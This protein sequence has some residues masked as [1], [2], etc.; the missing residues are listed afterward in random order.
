MKLAYAIDLTAA[1]DC[2]ISHVEGLRSVFR[3]L[4][5]HREQI[6]NRDGEFI[7]CIVAQ[8]RAN[9]LGI[10]AVKAG[11]DGGMRGE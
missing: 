2:K 5:S 8:I 10:E 4:P 11:T 6:L 7:H 9:E 3:I 1:T